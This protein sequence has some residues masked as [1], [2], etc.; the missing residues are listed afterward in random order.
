MLD[1]AFRFRPKREQLQTFKGLLS[2]SHGQN[3]ALTVFHVPVSTP[4]GSTYDR[5]FIE[6]HIKTKVRIWHV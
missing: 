2:E 3:L 6:T 1:P 5:D 4:S